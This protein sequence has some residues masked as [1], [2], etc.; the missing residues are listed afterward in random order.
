MADAKQGMKNIS[1]FGGSGRRTNAP[2][3]Y[4]DRRRQY[5]ASA[6]AAF[7]EAY[8]EYATDFVSA[9]MQG[10]IPGD[11]YRWSK[12]RIRLSDTT[13]Q[14][15]SLTRKTDDQKAFLVADSAVD[16]IPEGA[17]VETMGS[18]WLVTNPSNLSTAVGSGI[19]RRC[20]AVW[21]FLDWYGNVMEEPILVEKAQASAT[22]N[23]FQD[24]VTIMKGYF[25]IT[26]QKN[27]DTE[28][29]DQ[30]SRLILGRRAYHITGYADVTQ[31]FTGDNEST[32]LL[33]FTARMQ[34][35]N[36]ETDDMEA[37]VAGG[38]N[39]SWAVFVTGAPQM[40]VGDAAKF[41]A[42]SQRCGEAVENS[43]EHPIG[44]VWASD[45][46]TVAAVD[47]QGNVTAISE[48]TCRITAALDQN[49]AYG[50]SFTV[51]VEA[52]TEE[53]EAVRFLGEVPRYMAPYDMETVE[54]ALFIGG[55]KQSDAVKWSYSGAED[56]SY[57]VTVNGNT[58]TV[59]CWG[60]SPTPLHIE[61]ACRG[62]TA[63]LD[64]ELEG[65]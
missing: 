32:H 44:Y 51:S 3:Q 21:R 23:D 20:N 29:L 57:T 13:K 53:T 38:K 30:N 62:Q 11:F 48:G 10:L 31:E 27:T 9:R 19:M 34:E 42:S 2:E 24:S 14:G 28:Q 63:A 25:N 64:I 43:K 8:A 54:A 5:F 26:C 60:D 17:K 58:L 59:R 39:F 50:G 6:T 4:R 55:A 37:R 41:T 61:A 12:K 22:D 16:Y 49:R 56:S 65:F 1:L 33:Y 36:L 18:T 35:P 46:P 15:T 45:D 40:T 7:M 52:T 47:S